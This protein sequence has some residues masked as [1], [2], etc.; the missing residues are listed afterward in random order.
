MNFLLY[1]LITGLIM[2]MLANLN[3][4]EALEQVPQ[5]DIIG[6]SAFVLINFCV[7]FIITPIVV[8]M[9]IYNRYLKWRVKRLQKK[10]EILKQKNP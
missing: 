10:N 8:P 5:I 2:A 6:P 1:F 7:G 9:L 4:K 3:Y